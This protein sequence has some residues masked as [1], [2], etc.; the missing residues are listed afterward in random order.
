[1]LNG[2]LW[3][4]LIGELIILLLG[5]FLYPTEILVP[6]YI[7]MYYLISYVVIMV[8]LV[9]SN[10]HFKLSKGLLSWSIVFF[11][12]MIIAH[13]FC[14]DR[15]GLLGS[16]FDLYLKLYIIT[17]LVFMSLLGVIIRAVIRTLAV[18]FKAKK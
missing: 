5:I 2:R 7:L 16:C 3:V 18:V 4:I 14:G 8:A 12:G 9:D 1:M 6:P 10:L 17:P 13:Y 15:S 11:I